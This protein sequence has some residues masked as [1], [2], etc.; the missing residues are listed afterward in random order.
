MRIKRM[1]QK[2]ESKRISGAVTDLHVMA[3][4]RRSG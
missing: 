1:G 2:N 3:C 4:G